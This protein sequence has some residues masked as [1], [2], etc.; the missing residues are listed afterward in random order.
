MAAEA[1]RLLPAGTACGPVMAKFGWEALARA[2]D[3]LIAEHDRY[4]AGAAAAMP[5]VRACH[6]RRAYLDALFQLLEKPRHG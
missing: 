6:N 3:A 1:A 2:I 5:I 4:A